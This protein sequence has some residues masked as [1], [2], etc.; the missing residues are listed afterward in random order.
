MNNATQI[1]EHFQSIARLLTNRQLKQALDELDTFVKDVPEWD[2]HT[3]FDEIRTAYHYMLQYFKQ[4]ASDPQRARLYTNLLRQT[5]VLNERLMVAQHELV[6]STL[7]YSTLREQKQ[8]PRTLADYRLLFETFAEDMAMTRLLHQG[9][10]LNTEL[11]KLRSNHESSQNALF[12]KVWTSP[13]WDT[14]ML[15]EAR[16]FLWSVL[17]PVNDMAL[18]VSAVTLGLLQVFDVRKFHFLLDAYM[19]NDQQVNQRALVGITIACL[20][21]EKRLTFEP[22]L[23]ARL[24]L[25]QE[26]PNFTSNLLEIQIQLLRIRETKKADRKMRD[27]IIPEV[28]KSSHDLRNSKINIIELDE[29]TLLNDKNPEWKKW[30][31]NTNLTS[32]MQELGNMQMEGIDVYMSTFAQLKTFPFFRNICNW[33][34]PFDPQHS[35]VLQVFSEEEQ[36]KN[37]IVR[38]I[39]SSPYFCNSDKYSFCFTVQQIPAKQREMFSANLSEHSELTQD[40]ADMTKTER[41]TADI[42]SRQ[43]L[44]DLYRFFKVYPRRHEFTDIFETL[45]LNFQDSP[46]LRPFLYDTNARRKVAE[47]LFYKEYYM[48]AL[49]MFEALTQETEADAEL[50]QKLGFCYQKNKDYHK[51][52]ETYRQADLRKP[53]TL[54]TIRHL[55]QCHRLMKEPEAALPYYIKALEM[56]PD[57]LQLLLQTGECEVEMRLY[58]DAFT[59]FFKVEYLDTGSLRAKRC[60]AWCSFVT[61]KYAQAEKYYNTLLDTDKPDVQDC[62]NAGHTAWVQGYTERAVTLYLKGCRRKGDTEAFIA[63]LFKDKNELIRQG[64]PTDDLPLMAD[65]LRYDN[66]PA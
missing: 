34:Y 47:Y 18:F 62:L 48:E 51:A 54:W 43:Y 16:K 7:F 53:D 31:E 21:Y 30:E 33:F 65:T 22:E 63:L 56:Q 5:C 8:N 57:N 15:E 1:N 20:C 6:S 38:N 25:L 14:N 46:T 52:I 40:A 3:Q 42:I 29:E 13:I 12:C 58:D 23:S 35:A 44:Q 24:T 36:Q 55:A 11:D 60:I 9:D 27:E 19:H 4:N 28:I 39:L 41:L 50:Y 26:Q 61:G 37:F 49:R 2:M 10:Q 45:S 64:I 66:R 32:K 59:R 17:I